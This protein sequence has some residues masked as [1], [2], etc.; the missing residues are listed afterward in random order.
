MHRTLTTRPSGLA[1]IDSTLNTA[2]SVSSHK[3]LFTG[4]SIRPESKLFEGKDPVLLSAVSQHHAW[5]IQQVLIKRLL[6]ERVKGERPK[7]GCM[8]GVGKAGG[9]NA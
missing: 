7:A 3:C 8:V 1:H 5:L 9:G 6:D 4:M 2:I